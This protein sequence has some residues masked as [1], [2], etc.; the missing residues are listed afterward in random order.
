VK[1]DEARGNEE[2]GY[3]KIKV[4]N[5]GKDVYFVMQVSGFVSSKLVVALSLDL[6][7]EPV[8]YAS[9]FGWNINQVR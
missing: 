6:S 3:K 5:K 8:A 1:N 7:D 2:S 4:K 9:G